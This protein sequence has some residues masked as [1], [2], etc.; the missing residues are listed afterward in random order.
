[1]FGR[2]EARVGVAAIEA[3]SVLQEGEESVG[4]FLGRGGAEADG[5]SHAFADR[6]AV[7]GVLG[8]QVKHVARFE[9]PFVAGFEALEDANG[10]VLDQ[11]F[12]F[13]GAD[14]P[15]T[16]TVPAAEDVVAV[17]MG[18]DA[19]AIGGPADHHVVEAGV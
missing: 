19:A 11:V 9:H 5:V 3:E 14:A 8:W 6:D 10:Q 15:V 2:G 12:V 17:E 4:Q 18:S 16:V 7:M 1:M 13:L